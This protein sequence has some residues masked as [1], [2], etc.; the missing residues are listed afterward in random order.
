MSQAFECY[1]HYTTVAG[2]LGIINSRSIWMTDYRFLNDKLELHQGLNSFLSQ[3]PPDQRASFERAFRW[4][5]M[6]NHHCVFSLSRS[7]KILSQWRAYASDGS[8]MALGLTSRFL[9]HGGLSLVECRYEDHDTYATKLIQTHQPFIDAVH[10]ASE[11]YRAENSFMEWVT[12][13]SSGFY[14]LIADLIALK[15][16]A[17]SEEQELRAI[18]SRP[19]GDPSIKMREARNLIIPYVEAKI[20]PDE[21]ERKSMFVVVPEIWLGPKCSVLNKVSIL[22]MNI[23]MCMP[24]RHDCGY[25]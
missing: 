15:N 2:C 16:P 13:N 9:E 6:W 19:M 17:F 4:H 18:W 25:I 5:D 20:W 1:Y 24:Y 12:E 7:P 14:N 11:L 3:I 23:G 8:G 10:H 21:N 22:S